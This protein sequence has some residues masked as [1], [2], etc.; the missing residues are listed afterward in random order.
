MPDAITATLN[1][2]GWG[3]LENA[4]RRAPTETVNA[5]SFA[6]TKAATKVFN[7]SQEQVPVRQGTLRSTGFV[8]PVASL[9]GGFLA[10]NIS[11]GGPAA[12]YAV[13]QHDNLLYN[14]APGRKALYL[15][16]PMALAGPN[17]ALLISST[18]A[19][20]LNGLGF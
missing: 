13:E 14:H 10:T 7:E 5:V 11:Y 20:R 4:F 2:N 17:L 19:R 8:S 16:D 18:I 6:L 1:L 3:R 12:P 15:S 9:G